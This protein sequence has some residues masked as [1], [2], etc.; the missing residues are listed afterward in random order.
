MS[1][2]QDQHDC[3]G[4]AA[5]HPVSNTD[6]GHSRLLEVKT[7]FS[8]DRRKCLECKIEYAKEN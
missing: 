4:T 5:N 6:E 7:V 2:V 3:G 1:H 8:K